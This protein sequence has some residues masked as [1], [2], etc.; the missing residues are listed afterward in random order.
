MRQ[1]REGERWAGLWDFPRLDNND[2]NNLSL[3]IQQETGLLTELS[4][5]NHCI[6]HAVTR[7]RI[8][9]DC[10]TADS[11]VGRLQRGSRFSWKKVEEV[12][13][14]PLSVT[15]RKFAKK[16]LGLDGKK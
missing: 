13:G 4:S 6:K 12:D 2:L 3:T 16:F 1:C 11:V 7:F 10:Y 9:L 5:L 8:R 15:G 14:L